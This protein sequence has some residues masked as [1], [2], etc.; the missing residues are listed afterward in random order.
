MKKSYICLMA[1][2]LAVTSVS[3]NSDDP[4]DA[5]SKHVYAEGEAPY[6]RSSEQATV[7]LNME[8]QMVRIDQ[9]QY[10][11]LKD[12]AAY[13]HKNMNMTVDEAIAGLDNGS[14]VL[15][16]INASRQRWDL[17]PG[18]YGEYGWY[19]AANGISGAEDA[20]FTMNFDKETKLVEIKAVGVPDV[21]SMS[22]IDFGFAIKE[23]GAFDRYVRFT[24]RASVTDPSKVVISA[25]IP[26][27]GYGA[28]GIRFKDYD[29][30]FQL[31]M[32]MTAEEFI[33]ALESDQ[34]VMWLVD[35]D[36]NRVTTADGGH[37]DYTSNGY[38]YWLDSNGNIT[39][40]LP[41][42]YPDNMMFLE[43][44]GNGIYN[45]GNCETVTPA[46]T[47]ITVRFD[48]VSIDDPTCFLQ[49]IVAVTFD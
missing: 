26:G 30:S 29:E 7:T 8:F 42:S 43:Y 19:Y 34:I 28:Y 39:P 2:A 12:Y 14:V 24:A 35:A 38:G 45:I 25:N 22:S 3:C 40:W 48:F 49:F 33:K 10:I 20:L 13:F 36:G 46:G 23:N 11:N 6:L 41:T 4:S 32:G 27:E 5:C 16:T 47:Q 31:A 37:P 17:T 9:P 21:G 44:I 1:A 18:N 15:Y